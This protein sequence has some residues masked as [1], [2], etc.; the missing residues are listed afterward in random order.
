MQVEAALASN[1]YVDNIMV[2]AD[3][4]HNFCVALVVPS[5][6]VLEGWAREVGIKFKDLS[7][8]CEKPEATNEVLQSLTKVYFLPAYEEDLL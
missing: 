3:P 5:H 1:N 2:Y 8:L 4:F 7:E 6:Q